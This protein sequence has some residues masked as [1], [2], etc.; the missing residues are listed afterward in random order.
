MDY[1]HCLQFDL[2][3]Y[4][5]NFAPDAPNREDLIRVFRE[6]MVSIVTQLQSQL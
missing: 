3:A 5:R 6:E 1:Q 2:F 4:Y